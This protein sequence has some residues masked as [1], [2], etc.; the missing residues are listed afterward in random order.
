[1]RNLSWVMGAVLLAACEPGQ[2]G[3]AELFDPDEVELAESDAAL[4]NN[5]KPERLVVYNVNIENMIFDWKDL[6]HDM[7]RDDLRPDVFT[8]Q[9]VT[10]ADEM[11][12]LAGY[13]SRRLGVKYTGVVAKAN[14]PDRRFQNQITP[15][16]TVTTGIIFRD[17]RFDV[18]TRSSWMPW[19]KGLADQ[20]KTCDERSPH[21]GYETLRLKL[22]DKVAKKNIVVVSL[23]HWTWHSCN[24]KNLFEI[25]E[26]FER[27]PNAHAG[28]GTASA[29]HIVAGDFNEPAFEG[30]GDYKCWY[31]QMNRSVPQAQCANDDSLG[32]TEP[33]YEHCD[34]DRACT[35][36][37]TGIDFLFVRRSD[38]KKAKTDHFNVVSFDEAH[39]SSV[40]ATGG[41][42][43][44]NIKSR[45]GYNDQG[46]NYS[47]HK[48]MRAY[49]YYE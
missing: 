30:N 29:L 47:Q 19:G 18:V 4:R 40:K 26:G 2:A 9:Q 32:F 21:S 27:G 13:M 43:P 34:G 5:M 39:Q 15:R 37:L 7:S 16:P 17:A 10:D 44:S 36:R 42:G 22:F 33:A 20:P 48:A 1:M 41:D 49:V 35:N 46:P 23:R 31:R 25:D 8:V 45:D 11:Q 24:T 3:D 14:P 38:G 6:V 12:R 28:L